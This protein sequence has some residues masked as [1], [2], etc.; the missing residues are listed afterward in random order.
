MA[1]FQSQAAGDPVVELSTDASCDVPVDVAVDN[2]GHVYVCD[3]RSQSVKVFDDTI[4]KLQ[5]C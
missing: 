2:A 5:H 3:S 4:V 1:V